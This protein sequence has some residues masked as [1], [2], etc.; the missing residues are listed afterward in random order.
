MSDGPGLK[1]GSRVF[2]PRHG[3]GSVLARERREVGHSTAEF[4]VIGLPRGGKLLLPVDNVEP[5]GIRPLISASKARE[6]VELLER[7]PEPAR[8]ISARER[9]ATYADGLRSGAPDRY[10]EI[11]RELLFRSRSAKLS[12]ADHQVLEVACGYFIGEIG[13]VLDRSP[14][15]MAASL[16]LPVRNR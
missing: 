6:L 15:E 7:P 4:Y 10:T 8:E 5:A 3:V 14:A 2:C 1:V 16:D 13:A 9:A 12:S 11:L